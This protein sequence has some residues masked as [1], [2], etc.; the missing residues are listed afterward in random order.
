MLEGT[1][2]EAVRVKAETGLCLEQSEKVG[3]GG[4][5]LGMHPLCPFAAGT[6]NVSKTGFELT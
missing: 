2:T 4:V 6:R 1:R 3:N 5:C